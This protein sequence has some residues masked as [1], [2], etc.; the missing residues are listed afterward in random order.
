MV[1]LEFIYLGILW[2]SFICGLVSGI[3]LGKFS[4]ITVSI[5][6]ALSFFL[7]SIDIICIVYLLKFSHSLGCSVFSICSLCFSGL[8]I[9]TEISL[10]TEFLSSPVSSILITPA[11]TSSFY[12]SIIGL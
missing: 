9:S 10:D 12:C 3:N 4:V 7:S 6:A 2:A 5:I 1:V 11:K 8:V